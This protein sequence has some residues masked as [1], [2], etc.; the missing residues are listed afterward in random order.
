MN[1]LYHDKYLKYKSK[2][3]ALK[4]S[5]KMVGGA[6]KPS[7]LFFKLEGCGPCKMFQNIWNSLM[8]DTKLKEKVNLKKIEH[9]KNDHQEFRQKYKVE[10]FPT[11]I[12]DDGDKGLRFEGERT[13]ENLTK[14]I[15]SQQKN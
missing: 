6:D 9:G 5:Y 7:V 8:N 11:I 12:Y 1:S 4:N 2:Y 15:E 13:V 3:L 14:W 10:S